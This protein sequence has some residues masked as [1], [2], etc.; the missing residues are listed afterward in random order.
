MSIQ[1]SLFFIPVQGLGAMMARALAVNGANKVFIIGRR[2]DALEK[3]ASSVSTGNIIPL[4]GDVT[5][6]ESLQSC[7]D[8]VSSQV[9]HLDVVVCNSGISGPSMPQFKNPKTKEPL[10]FEEFQ[11]NLWKPEMADVTSTFNVNISGKPP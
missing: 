5:S 7:V 2:S 4:P 11:K 10:P 9:S 6:K 3:V 8:Q 1:H